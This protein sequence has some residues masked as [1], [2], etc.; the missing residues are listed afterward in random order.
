MPNIISMY[1]SDPEI[2][3]LARD[4]ALKA[5]RKADAIVTD[6]EI[7]Y[8][9]LSYRLRDVIYNICG[10]DIDF[11]QFLASSLSACLELY[12]SASKIDIFNLLTQ[13]ISAPANFFSS[14]ISR[15]VTDDKNAH[16]I[17]SL[18]IEIASL[19]NANQNIQIIKTEE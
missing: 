12:D 2:E 13:T 17:S 7:G 18:W 16:F 8:F 1:R 9:I 10:R 3:K 5:K 11:N 4:K 6:S 19:F 14:T 15:I